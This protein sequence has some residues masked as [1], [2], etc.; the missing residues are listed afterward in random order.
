MK[1]RVYVMDCGDF[2]KIGVSVNVGRRASQIPYKVN[3]IFSTDEMEDAFKIER[4]MHS[5][6]HDKR[7][8]N[9]QGREF[10]SIP[11]DTA[12]SELKRKI[13]VKKRRQ[14]SDFK[15]KAILR[16]IPLLKYMDEF[17][18]GYMLAI[19][20]GKRERNNNSCNTQEHD[21]LEDG[22][23]A[24]LSLNEKDLTLALTYTVALRD[25]EIAD[26]SKRESS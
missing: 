7:C 20:E 4:E 2:V 23:D 1:R 18:L 21:I 9:I 17:N 11:F 19:A 22:I 24:L 16:L 12:V 25:K 14:T 26:S 8:Q 3:R 13:G 5:L 15:Q 10:F 6:F